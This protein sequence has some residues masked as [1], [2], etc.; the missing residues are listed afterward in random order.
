MA[1]HREKAERKKNTK[2]KSKKEAHALRCHYAQTIRKNWNYARRHCYSIFG[3][4]NAGY[5]ITSGLLSYVEISHYFFKSA[6]AVI[7]EAIVKI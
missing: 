7:Y 4:S 6:S 2:K 1:A 5:S 3:L